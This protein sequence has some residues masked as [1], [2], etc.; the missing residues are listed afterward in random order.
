L[1]EK[2]EK[3]RADYRKLLSKTGGLLSAHKTLDAEGE[4]DAC[5]AAAA[6]TC[7]RAQDKSS[8]IAEQ[9]AQA[10]ETV[11]A[12]KLEIAALRALA[13][14]AR[15]GANAR[16]TSVAA[17]ADEI[18]QRE[19]LQVHL[20]E[21][22][23][24]KLQVQASEEQAASLRQALEH[25]KRCHEEALRPA[26]GGEDRAVEPASGARRAGSRAEGGGGGG[27]GRGRGTTNPFDE[28]IPLE[29]CEQGDCTSEGQ[30]GD[31]Q[32]R[33]QAAR[34][35]QAAN[36]TI[37]TQQQTLDALRLQL[38]QR[39]QAHP[40]S[41]ALPAQDCAHTGNRDAAGSTNEHC[42]GAMQGGGKGNRTAACASNV[43]MKE[44]GSDGQ[45][46]PLSPSER[47][48]EAQFALEGARVRLE[49]LAGEVRELE[50]KLEEE[51]AGRV[52]VE[53][54][55]AALREEAA[56]V[57]QELERAGAERMDLEKVGRFLEQVN[58][59]LMRR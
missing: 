5:S 39:G 24:L 48:I 17:D 53:R 54:E 18:V 35:L 31:E 13:R 32:A 20:D 38:A 52:E 9:H 23:T 47:R 6:Q 15:A 30:G 49:E 42:I 28:P 58:L 25:E 57:R 51:A 2:L 27:G 50:R 21:I 29:V 22:N 33:M 34:E 3:A 14:P 11:E 37:F 16:D 41:Y 46:G 26:S 10:L 59:E 19:Q 45:S 40:Q 1:Q 43:G 7:S 12:L 36:E 8:Q 56:S 44:G 55:R 4:L